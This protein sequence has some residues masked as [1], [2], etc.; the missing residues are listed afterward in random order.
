MKLTSVPKDYRP[1]L[2]TALAQGWTLTRTPHGRHPILTS[3]DGSYS[4]P[5]PGSS[6]CPY[7]LM[8][9]KARLRKNGLEIQ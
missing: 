6:T 1:L 8:A 9:I 2:K 7:L 4:T 3:P 5:L